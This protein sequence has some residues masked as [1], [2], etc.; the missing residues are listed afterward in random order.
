MIDDVHDHLH[1]RFDLFLRLCGDRK[2]KVVCRDILG[3][4][5]AQIVQHLEVCRGAHLRLCIGNALE[6]GYL[7][8]DCHQRNRVN[9]AVLFQNNLFHCLFP[10]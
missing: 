7:V 3:Q 6:L 4:G 2:C 5:I 8:T 1:S 9:I 10:F